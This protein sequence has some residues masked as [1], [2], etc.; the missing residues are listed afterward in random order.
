MS[1]QPV[2]PT[3]CAECGGSGGVDSGGV[4][5]W[6]EAIFVGCPSCAKQKPVEPQLKPCPFCGGPAR[7][8]TDEVWFFGTTFSHD[9]KCGLCGCSVG[10]NY[11][12]TPEQAVSRW[13]T[14]AGDKTQ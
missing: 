4:Y 14:R 12:D 7:L 3:K 10:V 1:D 11:T 2:G 6:G 9:V 5:P 13:N 8:K